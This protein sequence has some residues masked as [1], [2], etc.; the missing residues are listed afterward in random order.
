MSSFEGILEELKTISEYTKDGENMSLRNK[1][2]FSGWI[3]A[4]RAVYKCDKLIEW[5]SL[6]Q[7]FDDW[8]YEEFE[9]KKQRTYDYI[10]LYKLM[11]IAPKLLNC[12]VNMTYSVK[13]P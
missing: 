13:K 10:S 11:S 6:P 4:A 8:M 3:A 1:A 7:R 5:Q 2:L 12:Q 9:I